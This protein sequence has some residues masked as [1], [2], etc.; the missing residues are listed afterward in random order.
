MMKQWIVA[1]LL[2]AALPAFAQGDVKAGAQKAASCM[3]CHGAEVERGAA[4]P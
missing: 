3:A 4:L 1:A 2:V